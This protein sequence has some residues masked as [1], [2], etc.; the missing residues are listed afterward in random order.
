MN[1]FSYLTHKWLEKHGCIISFVATAD[2][3]LKH[4]VTSIHSAKYLLYW[5]SL[6]QN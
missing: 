3:V 1:V 6:R 4:Q 5:A 2:L